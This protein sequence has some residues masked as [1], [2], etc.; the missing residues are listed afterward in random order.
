MPPACRHEEMSCS[1]P[2]YWRDAA[3]GGD[4]WGKLTLP[5]KTIHFQIHHDDRT[6]GGQASRIGRLFAR[7]DQVIRQTGETSV[8]SFEKELEVIICEATCELLRKVVPQVDISLPCDL[9]SRLHADSLY[10]DA[11]VEGDEVVSFTSREPHPQ[12]EELQFDLARGSGRCRCGTTPCRSPDLP[13]AHVGLGLDTVRSIFTCF[14]EEVQV[15]QR[16]QLDQI[17]RVTIPS[18][19]GS[20]EMLCKVATNEYVFE[21][22][23]RELQCLL[24]VAG[25]DQ[26]SS[27]P[28]ARIPKLLGIIRSSDHGG[29]I[30]LVETYVP[31]T[32]DLFRMDLT[33][34][35]SSRRE[36]WIYQIN[37]TIAAL[38][39]V[40][41]TWSDVKADNVLIHSETDEAWLIDFGGGG[42]DKW[43]EVEG[44]GSIEGDLA[45]ARKLE[46]YLRLGEQYR[47]TKSE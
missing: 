10:F 22:V 28:L 17:T 39:K 2:W 33:K 18:R 5:H 38:H 23:F 44:L 9:H 31:H 34:V 21:A 32:E 7:R 29:I 15:L 14:D 11:V 41:I 46:D 30:G 4:A 20:Q 1:I 43:A 3:V 16:L 35:D 24:I 8:R 45:V 47:L 13:D 27:S 37:E 6:A 26:A 12:D 40:G 19:S 25:I 36:K 42:T